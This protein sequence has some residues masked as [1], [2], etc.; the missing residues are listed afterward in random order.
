MAK[1]QVVLTTSQS[2]GKKAAAIANRE[3]VPQPKPVVVTPKPV[4]K[5]KPVTKPAAKPRVIPAV[6]KPTAARPIPGQRMPASVEIRRLGNATSD[7]LFIYPGMGLP[8]N[9]LPG[10]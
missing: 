1:P 2:L 9:T 3:P 4:V 6:S 10:I 5:P 7:A 8:S